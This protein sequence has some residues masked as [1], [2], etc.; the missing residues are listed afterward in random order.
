MIST[1][2]GAMSQFVL[3]N[4][5]KAPK[6]GSVLSAVS[7]TLLLSYS[8]EPPTLPTWTGA[9]YSATKK[10]ED[11]SD[12]TFATNHNFLTKEVTHAKKLSYPSDETGLLKHL[13]LVIKHK[14]KSE[15]TPFKH[16]EFLP[17]QHITPYVM[18]FQPYD[19]SP[20]SI[21]LTICAGLKIEHA[22]IS[23]VIVNI[24]QPESSLDDNNAQ[25]L[26]SAIRCSLIT[27]VNHSSVSTDNRVSVAQREPLD[28]TNQGV[29]IAFRSFAKSVLPV[30]DNDSVEPDD[31]TDPATF[32]ITRESHHYSMD[33]GFNVKAGNNGKVSLHPHSIYLWSS[34]R[35][36]HKKKNPAPSDI[37][38]FSTLRHFYGNNV[39]L[40]RSKNP[41]LMIPH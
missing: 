21:G 31:Q 14:H 22:D 29:M 25:I 16:V 18:Y 9:K 35:Y 40:S 3:S 26:Q 32:G 23:G 24:E 10:D 12:K 34:F 36:V 37:S 13:Y 11:E 1:F 17:S 30:F 7:G 27:R 33:Q 28:R 4:E 39:T 38:M 6:Y 19:V 2:I 15:D 41:A 8:I 20:S 5:P